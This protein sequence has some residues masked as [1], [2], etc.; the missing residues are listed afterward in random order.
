MELISCRANNVCN[1]WD[2]LWLPLNDSTLQTQ[3][4]SGEVTLSYFIYV[5]LAQY[6]VSIAKPL[7]FC[8]SQK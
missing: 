8:F 2:K 6:F 1:V 7:H 5:H 4:L 3:T